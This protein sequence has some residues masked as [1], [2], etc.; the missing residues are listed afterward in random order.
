[1]ALGKELGDIFNCAAQLNTQCLLVSTAVPVGPAVTRQG[2]TRLWRLERPVC[3]RRY[4]PKLPSDGHLFCRTPMNP[5]AELRLTS[6]LAQMQVC[7]EEALL[8]NLCCLFFRARHPD[9]ET[10]DIV[11]MSFDELLKSKHVLG[12]ETNHLPSANQ[13][14]RRDI[15]ALDVCGRGFYRT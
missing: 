12:I 6:K 11:P 8:R 7:G 10:I 15:T 5:G 14:R 1:M 3:G 9:C 4:A 2:G 13:T